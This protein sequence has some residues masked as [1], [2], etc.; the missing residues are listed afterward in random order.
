MNH[1]RCLPIRSF[2]IVFSFM[3]VFSAKSQTL[4]AG[5]IAFT[6]YNS[7][8]GGVLQNDFS[9]IVLI[10]MAAGTVI[11]FTDNGYKIAG[12][13]ALGTTEGTLTW[14]SPALPRFTQVYVQIN[15]SGNAVVSVSAGSIAAGFSN[16]ILS[17]AGDQILAYQ[18]LSTSPTFISAI[19]M[20]SDPP[21]TQ[22]GWDN[23]ASGT[24]FSGNRSDVPPG[25]TSGVNCVAPDP[26][27]GISER[28][29]GRYACTGSANSTVP[30][31]RT[32]INTPANWIIQ[33]LNRYT[34]PPTTCTFSAAT[35]PLK[36]LSF[37][38]K[39]TAT[40][41]SF[42]WSTS[43]ESGVKQ[44]V[45][46]RS[47]DAV[48]FTSIGTVAAKNTVGT[49]Q[50]QFVDNRILNSGNGYYRLKMEDLDGVYEY[51]SVVLLTN[52][53]V[54]KERF[55]ISRNAS[56]PN[57]LYITSNARLQHDVTINIIDLYGRK[58]YTQN[59]RADVLNNGNAMVPLAALHAGSIYIVQIRDGKSGNVTSM[60]FQK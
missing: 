52:L 10:N 45:I 16:F 38:G 37:E 55:S 18:G 33:D 28:D 58:L 5:N 23:L 7:N 24:I 44:F 43:E 39:A 59:L 46:E 17:Q 1:I 41:N 14:T 53:S 26:N 60:K 9:F 6:G 22:A 30:A 3:F 11:K 2:A 49:Y 40:S 51:S 19:H 56:N 21:A 15:P 20:N 42:T 34:L 57:S 32:A 31:V 8:N 36:L 54:P 4:V 47:G 12:V 48:N 27:I 35:L 29:N 25:L 50:Y 13:N